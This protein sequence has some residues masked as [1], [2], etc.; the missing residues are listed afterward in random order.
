VKTFLLGCKRFQVLLCVFA[1]LTIFTT[2]CSPSFTQQPY[3]DPTKN[4]HTEEGFRNPA[5]SPVR[6]SRPFRLF[7]FIFQGLTEDFDHKS[8]PKDHILAKT[9]IR[10]QLSAAPKDARITWIGHATFLI[11][12]NGLNILTDPHFTNRASPVSFAGPKRYTP[13]ALTITELPK[14][15]VILVSH[16]H[17]DSLDE[18]SFRQLARHSPGA[19]VLVPLGNADLLREWG[20]KNIREVDWYDIEKFGEVTFQSTPAIH[21]SNR[22]I[23]DVNQTLWSGFLITG[24]LGQATRKIWFAGDTGF[25]PVFKSEVT[26]KIGGVDFALVPIGAFLPQDIMK[27]VHTTPEEAL[28]ISRIMSAKVVIPMHWGTFPLGEDSPTLGKRR[29]LQAPAPS[30]NKVLMKIGQTLDLRK[31]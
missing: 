8:I 20:M 6:V 28:L 13:P 7:R 4:H 30:M 29:F 27:P 23:F 11:G 24:V 18:G 26:K 1:N 19:R 17:Y 25:G 12:L 2:A 5:G 22:S 31:L 9:E 3:Y 10:E 14:I 15:D 16:N 21:R